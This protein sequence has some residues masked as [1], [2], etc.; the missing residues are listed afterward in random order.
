MEFL[1]FPA[2]N[3]ENESIAVVEDSTSYSYAVLYQKIHEFKSV[4]FSFSGKSDLLEE[5]IALYLP[6]SLNYIIAMHGIWR[7]G[8]IVVPLNIASTLP[9]IQYYLTNATA[10]KLITLE[11]YADILRDLCTDLGIE[12]ILI[13]SL[14]S[15]TPLSPQDPLPLIS[16]E[17]RAMI[18]FTSGTT[19]KPK[20]VV[21]T[22]SNIRSQILSLVEAWEWS[23][24]DSI[25]LFLPV[26][27]IHG[28]INILSCCL[29]SGATLYPFPK[30][31]IPRILNDVKEGKYSLFMAV[32]TVY[33]KLIQYLHSSKHSS[34][35]TA[36][37]TSDSTGT[38]SLSPED[39][40][41]ITQSFQRMR[42]NVSGSAACPVPLF[43]QWKELTGQV[44]LERYGMT[45]IGMA[46]SNP[47]HGSRHPG[48]VG[49]PLPGV[50][51]GLF[52]EDDILIDSID[53][54]GE[55]RVKG[56]SVFLEYWN[57]REATEKTFK[58]GW[59]CSG[60]M[61]TRDSDGY[62]VI[63]GRTSLDIIKSGG[64]KL[65]ALEIENVLLEHERVGECAVVG[66]PDEVWGESVAVAIVLKSLDEEEEDVAAAVSLSFADLKEWCQGRMSS[67]KIPKQMLLVPSLPRNAM[68]KVTKQE[69]KKMF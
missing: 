20:G 30:F 1:S 11:R 3:P 62:Y 21:T 28:I 27:H 68:G 61:A 46:I 63:L 29:W 48:A 14:P 35:T 67:Y 24:T 17:R 4:L 60:D 8:G 66:V 5:R 53:T 59:F 56:N 10:T 64:Y 50:Q 13:D 25:P 15:T 65:S 57:H 22:H 23:P 41:L 49:F 42:L 69:V 58:D 16:S 43:N 45:E 40:L 39:K 52:S 51:I 6:A 31:D 33:V 19:S 38:S 55:I 26:H 7:A 34:T 12:L 32:P 2:I 54:P 36:A 9:E 37:S 44:L 18:L 47:L